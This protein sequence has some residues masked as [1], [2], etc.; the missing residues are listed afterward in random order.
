MEEAAQSVKD[1]YGIE[2]YNRVY[3]K[4]SYKGYIDKEEEWVLE[5]VYD[6]SRVVGIVMAELSLFEQK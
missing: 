6:N 3:E 2:A 5:I 4:Y 1:R